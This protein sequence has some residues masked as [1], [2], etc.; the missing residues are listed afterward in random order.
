VRMTNKMHTLFPLF[1]SVILSCA[2]FKQTSYHQQVTSVHVAYSICHA[3][4]CV[5]CL[6]ANTLW[7]AA[8]TAVTC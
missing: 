7:D 6:V 1:V 4:T 3:C 5:W 8:C 2:C